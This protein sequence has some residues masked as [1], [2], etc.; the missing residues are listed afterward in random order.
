MIHS[1]YR[2]G[3]C[4]KIYTMSGFI[5]SSKKDVCKSLLIER[6]MWY[7]AM[8]QSYRIGQLMSLKELD[9]F[10]R[11]CIPE[12][13][14]HVVVDPVRLAGISGQLDVVWASGRELCGMPVT[15]MPITRPPSVPYT[16]S[17]LT[18]HFS[19]T[20]GPSKEHRDSV[21]KATGYIRLTI[22]RHDAYAGKIQRLFTGRQ[23]QILQ[24]IVS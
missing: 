19:S 3:C 12:L 14:I 23:V 17:P 1:L 7:V 16:Q 8:W 6:A 20:S 4:G 15:L 18:T 13:L 11:L 5:R 24:N 9:K 21:V 10:V 22:V 2:G